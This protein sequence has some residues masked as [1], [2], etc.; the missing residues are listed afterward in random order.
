M[1]KTIRLAWVFSL[2]LLTPALAQASGED[3]IQQGD[4]LI[5]ELGEGDPKG[6]IEKY[7][8]ALA[9]GADEFDVQWRIA[10]AYFWWSDWQGDNATKKRLGKKGMTAGAKAIELKPD[11]VEGHYFYALCV[12]EYSLGIS[13]IKAITQGMEKK[14]KKSAE[15]AA[16]IELD[17]DGGGPLNALGRF[18]Y[19]LPWPKRNLKKSRDL[20]T[21]NLK[22]VPDSARTRVY[23]AETLIALKDKKGAK[24]QLDYVLA[25][26]PQ[27]INKADG[28]RYKKRAEALRGKL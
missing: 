23:L 9:D 4:S 14:F 3:L 12:G 28:N 19:E 15:K 20:L 26:E 21:K 22:S 7:E 11:R 6:A 1:R 25:N 17:F 13:I 27:A 16:S 2:I 18:Y 10:R 24:E 5:E 8:A